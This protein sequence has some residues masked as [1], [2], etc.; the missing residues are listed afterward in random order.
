L[1]HAHLSTDDRSSVLYLLLLNC[2]LVPTA[3]G[4]GGISGIPGLI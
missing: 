3:I 4:G 2:L 1:D